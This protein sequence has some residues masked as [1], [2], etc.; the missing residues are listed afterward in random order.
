[1]IRQSILTIIGGTMAL[2]SLSAVANAS[3]NTQISCYAYV[4]AQCYGNGENNCSQDDY[5]WG[6]GQCDDNYSKAPIRRVERPK[7]LVNVPTKPG[8]RDQIGAAFSR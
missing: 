3:H 1:M 8:I 2:A 6:L 7:G 4:H 5:E